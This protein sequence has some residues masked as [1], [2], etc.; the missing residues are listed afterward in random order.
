[1]SVNMGNV[2]TGVVPLVASMCSLFCD[3]SYSDSAD[4]GT[5]STFPWEIAFIDCIWRISKAGRSSGFL[6]GGEVPACRRCLSL[7]RL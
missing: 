3:V 4:S 5:C 6:S 1:M 7:S 2:D